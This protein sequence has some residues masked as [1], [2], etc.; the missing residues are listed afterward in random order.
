MSSAPPPAATGP[1]TDGALPPLPPARSNLGHIVVPGTAVW[2][3]GFVVLL[4]FVEPLRRHHAML[5][6][7]TF[8]AGWVLGLIGL[9]IYAWQRWA[10]RRGRR[11]ANQMALDEEF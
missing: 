2:F 7:W 9:S 1:G 3:V 6:L 11:S 5:W 10:A 8:L 4:F